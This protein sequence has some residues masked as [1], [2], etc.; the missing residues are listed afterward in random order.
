M[1]ARVSTSS[2]SRS[3]SRIAGAHVQRL[4]GD[5]Q[6]LG[7]LLQHLRARLAQPALDLAQIRIRHPGGIGELPQRQLRVAPLLTQILTEIADVERCHAPTLHHL[8]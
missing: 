7:D 5:P 3:A 4:G 2:R 8:R 6:R 1:T